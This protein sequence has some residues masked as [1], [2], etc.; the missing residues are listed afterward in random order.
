[1][2]ERKQASIIFPLPI[3]KIFVQTLCLWNLNW[4][5]LSV[6]EISC[7]TCYFFVSLVCLVASLSP[8]SLKVLL[9]EEGPLAA[10]SS[11]SAVSSSTECWTPS[12]EVSDNDISRVDSPEVSLTSPSIYCQCL[13][14][15]IIYLLSWNSAQIMWRILHNS[16]SS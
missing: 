9:R 12:F 10:S 7:A 1:M 6:S 2:S 14:E 5:K 11:I 15:C 8:T 13:L 4:S 16:C 3:T